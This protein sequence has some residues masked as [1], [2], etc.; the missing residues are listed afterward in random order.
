MTPYNRSEK[1]EEYFLKLEAQK[2]KKLAEEHK[3]ET[4][5]AEKKRLKELHCMKCPKCGMDLK[6]IVYKEVHIDKCFSCD[7][8]WLDEGELEQLAEKESGDGVLAK[9]TGLFKSDVY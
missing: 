3:K 7:G 5:D 8:V 1:E 6:E 4:E 2:L 9:F